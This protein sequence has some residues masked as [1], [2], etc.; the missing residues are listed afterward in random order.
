MVGHLPEIVE[1]EIDGDPVPVEVTIPVTINGRIFPRE[2]RDIWAFVARQGQAITC[3]VQAARLGSPLDS[4]LEIF[5][6]HG[7]RIA[8]N[9]D[10]FGADSLVQFTAP[11]TG[12]YQVRIHDVNFRGGQAFVYRL[13]ITADPFVARVF[14]LGGR[15]NSKVPLELLGHG[16]PKE[17][18]ATSIPANIPPGYYHEQTINNKKTNPFMLD[19]DDL[20][21]YV[22]AEPKQPPDLLRPIAVPAVLNGRI[23][24]P[25]EIDSWAVLLKKGVTYRLELRAKILDSPLLGIVTVTNQGGKELVKSDNS[26]KSRIDPLL[27]FTAPADGTYIVQVADTFATRGGREYAYRLRITSSEVPELRLYFMEDALTLSRGGQT[28]LKLAVERLAA[29]GPIQLA[30]E[31]LP[32]GVTAPELQIGAGQNTKELV[33]KAET[34]APIR[35]G[36]ITIQGSMKIGDKTIS[37]KATLFGTGGQRKVDT[38]LAAVALPA[39]FKIVG[40]YDMRWAPRGTIFQRQYQIERGGFSGPLEISLADRQAR[41][42]QGVAGA[43]VQVPAGANE[44]AYAIQLPPTMEMGRTCRVC[45]MA[46]GV[47]TDSDGAEHIVSYCSIQPNEQLILVVEPGK[48]EVEPERNSYVVKRGEKV[49][50]GVNVTRE[51]SLQAPV[52]LELVRAEHLKLFSAEPVLMQNG[53]SRGAITILVGA[54][55]KIPVNQPVKIRATLMDRGQPIIAEAPVKL[56]LEE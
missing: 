30:V 27:E 43:A 21:E 32:S 55:E 19:V 46:T 56:L 15:R 24:P 16:L 36:R 31:G 42:L 49:V 5:D 18:V 50:V 26:G 20:L 10:Y 37:Q 35:A 11:A 33:L 52:K 54:D 40:K 51:K 6:P 39:P 4:R 9:D 3:E 12:K 48:L 44:F 2:N 29:P 23:N 1:Q 28:K 45:V 8:E 14:P 47:F 41:H 25:G 53:Q 34:A 17:P 7:R 38:V 22:E 13:T